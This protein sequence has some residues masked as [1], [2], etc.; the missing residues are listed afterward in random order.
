MASNA[1]RF[2]IPGTPRVRR[3]WSLVA[4]TA[5]GA[6]SLVV[7]A[8]AGYG[9]AFLCLWLAAGGLLAVA[10]A[11][12]GARPA[13]IAVADVLAAGGL[14]V[15]FAPL[16]LLRAY[17]RP[18]QVGSDEVAIMSSARSWAERSGVDPFG[19]SDY[20]G[21]PAGLLVV[22]GKL[23]DLIG[24]VDLLHMRLLH[25]ALGLA[26]IAAAY[27]LFRQLQPRAW[28]IFAAC[29]LGVSHS[30]L[31]ISRMAMRE[32]TAVLL[33]VVALA[34]LVRGLRHGHQLSSY[35]GGV[36]AGLGFYVYYPARFTI[37]VWAVFLAGV[38]LLARPAFGG[39]RLR[40]VA[41]A[42]ALGFVLVATPI[43]VAEQ[44]APA[45]QVGLQREALLIF[46]QARAKQQAWV[47]ASSEWEAVA[48][49]VVWG[50]TAFNNRV[51]DHSWIYVNEGHGFVD[52]VTGVLLWIGVA[53]VLVAALRRRGDPWLLLALCCFAILWLSFALLVNKAPNYTRLLVTLPFVALLATAAVRLLAGLTERLA[54]RFAPRHARRA[55]V[56][57]AAGALVL[58]AAA[59][60]SIARDYVD[61]GVQRGD[62]IGDTGRYVEAHR[63]PPGK[64]F[65]IAADDTDRYEYYDWGFASMWRERLAIFA[66]DPARV[67]EVISPAA[68]ASFDAPAPFALFMRRELWAEHEARLVA[69][70]GTA[71]TQPLSRDGSRIVV[72]VGS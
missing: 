52:P 21:H 26:T 44:R 13:R 17:S 64:R 5:L 31:M 62:L 25:G 19:V 45:G 9:P 70:Y 22:L 49:N 51:V 18:V 24:G 6:G 46:E 1:G 33:E 4:G 55:G 58:V 7:Y 69:R 30:L 20:L 67:G 14:V 40:H 57:V 27:L 41:A 39:A 59:N 11:L 36:V 3:T 42:T 2:P 29:V 12:R 10:F 8:T 65:Y 71:W 34:L 54:G 32:N 15:A 61:T 47:F 38:A 50:L 56:A 66:G 60:L 37:V 53:A 16:Y 63:D 48:K 43:L 35:L 28:A 72:E 68:L 23:G